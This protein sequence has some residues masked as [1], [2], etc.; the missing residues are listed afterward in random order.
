MS[1]ATTTQNKKVIPAP[2]GYVMRQDHKA[3][4]LW[5]SDG[6]DA[7]ASPWLVRCAEHGTTTPAAN[8]TTDGRAKGRA[9][10]R[11]T[12]CAGCKAEGVT[13]RRAGGATA[14]GLV[15]VKVTVTVDPAKWGTGE[16][17][18][19]AANKAHAEL[20]KQ[21]AASTGV[22]EA[23][24]A[25]LAGMVAGKARDK[26]AVREAVRAEVRDYLTQV[27][28]ADERITET[29]AAVEVA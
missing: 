14:P 17:D 22:T 11:V 20:A 4:Q 24:A 25:E 29:S 10:E 21:I 26:A 19:E 6:K 1:E 28:A 7:K 16:G 27:L 13:V 12:W 3:F 2:K 23:K 8:A 15:K 5:Q 18:D 9:S